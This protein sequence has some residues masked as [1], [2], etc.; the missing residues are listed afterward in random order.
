MKK[1]VFI[2]LNLFLSTLCYSQ[3][4][5]FQ[6]SSHILDIGAGQPAAHVEVKL[7]KLI[8]DKS[9]WE[10]MGVRFTDDNGRINDFLPLS[11]S[12]KGV[13]KLTF[14]TEAYF[15][16]KK[17]ETFY[18]YIEVIFKISGDMHYHVP[19]TLSPYGYSTYRGS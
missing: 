9:S 7:Q 13:Y 10:D 8:P 14:Y 3:S 12:N 1:V 11:E 15:K 17:T 16:Q 18:P 4:L 5:K 2:F 6:L 19:I